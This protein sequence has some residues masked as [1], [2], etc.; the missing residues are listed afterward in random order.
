MEA[1]GCR[2][3]YSERRQYSSCASTPGHFL[4]AKPCDLVMD[5]TISCPASNLFSLSLL[6]AIIYEICCKTDMLV[7]MMPRNMLNVR[8]KSVKGIKEDGF[9]VT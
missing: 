3:A 5:R 8:M 7:D 6:Q 2:R 4:S 1:P 9:D